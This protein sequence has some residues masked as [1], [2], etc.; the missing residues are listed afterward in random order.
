MCRITVHII[1]TMLLE[2]GVTRL[3]LPS[4]E[5][6]MLV[7]GALGFEACV[8]EDRRRICGIGTLVFPGT[9]VL[10]RYVRADSLTTLPKDVALCK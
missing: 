4:V 6:A 8:G 3:S 5:T 2:L 10:Q 1:E 7:W 9:S